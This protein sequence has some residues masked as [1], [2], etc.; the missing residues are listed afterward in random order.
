M[1]VTAFFEPM[2]RICPDSC[3]GLDGVGAEAG[4]VSSGFGR[5]SLNIGIYL[6]ER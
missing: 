6:L 3:S 4:E 5:E 2:T 1:I